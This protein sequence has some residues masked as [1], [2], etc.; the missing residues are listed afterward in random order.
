MLKVYFHSRCKN[1]TAV[2][3]AAHNTSYMYMYIWNAR[4]KVVRMRAPPGII[5]RPQ[6]PY[7]QIYL[8]GVIHGQD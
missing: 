8:A 7:V 1:I 6:A 4:G 2:G 5:A 3:I